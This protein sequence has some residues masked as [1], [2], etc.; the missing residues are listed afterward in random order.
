M[1]LYGILAAFGALIGWGVGDFLI[2]KVTRL[3]GN[4]RTLLYS[5]S[6][7]F[8]VLLPFAWPHLDDLAAAWEN[9]L[10]LVAV[11]VVVY[12]N[13]FFSFEAL[14]KGKIAV[15]APVLSLELPLTVT[16]AVALHGERLWWAQVAAITA[17]FLGFL[18]VIRRKR[19]KGVWRK[20]RFERG[21]AYALIG[22]LGLAF[23]NFMVGVSSQATSP[24]V[25]SW[26]IGTTVMVLA[27]LTL[28]IR[29]EL[30]WHALIDPLKRH[31][32]LILAQ[33]TMTMGAGLCFAYATTQIPI[34]VTTGISEGYVALAAMLG[35]FVNRE[36]LSRTQLVGVAVT[37]TGILALAWMTG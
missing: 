31:P 11:S 3:V 27:F 37:V 29:R 19:A 21:V 9:A 26:V 36:R 1:A 12:F 10:L 30:G 32:R 17:V 13:A 14:R 18:F 4:F 15:I 23:Y 28:A 2:Q 35:L 7:G 6:L 22:V 20:P 34:S 24:I 33:S 16:L 25:T 8:L 5:G